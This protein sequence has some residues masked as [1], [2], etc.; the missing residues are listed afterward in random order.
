[1]RL[2]A[3]EA[4]R[5]RT[6]QVWMDAEARAEEA[7]RERDRLAAELDT[8]RQHVIASQSSADS[9][10]EASEA[11]RARTERVSKEA[12]ARA[13]QAIRDRDALV[14]ER[15][16]AR[17]A[18][19]DAQA[20]VEARLQAFDGDRTETEQALKSAEARAEEAIRERDGL[21]AELDAARQAIL[22]MQAAVD[23]RL[24]AI[25]AERAQTE[26]AWK[27]AEARDEAIRERDAL[28][29]ELDVARQTVLGMQAAVDARLEKIAAKRSRTEQAWKDAEAR[30]EQAIR[31]RDALAAE[32]EAARQA[33]T[34]DDQ[35]DL[36]LE[37]AAERIRSLELQLFERGHGPQNR[38]VDLDR[39]LDSPSPPSGQ[40]IRRATR[41]SFSTT[42]EVYIDGALG[43]LVDLSVGG[44]QVLCATKPPV[45]VAVTLSLLSDEIPVSC[46]GK[47]M[48]ARPEPD[49]G[50]RPLTHRAGISFT[51]ADE[52]AVEAFIIRYSAS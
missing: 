24:E 27:D 38:D 34:P 3:I 49:S 5:A 43:E 37:A 51:T 23:A 31:E 26:Q 10:L 12:E 32:L 45:N 48:W 52:A 15:D 25:D 9:R 36:R 6:E 16:A 11:E 21:A 44:A 8:G 4:E 46:Q 13:E 42:I 17:Q 20:A 19:G 7:I 1:M 39:Q 35:K 41:Y 50:G 18:A 33:A 47:I 14:A 30:E 40:P 29:A 2:E 28:A 22:D